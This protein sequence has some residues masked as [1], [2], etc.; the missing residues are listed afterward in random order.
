MKARANLVQIFGLSNKTTQGAVSGEKYCWQISSRKNIS[1]WVFFLL[2]SL[3]IFSIDLQ[4]NKQALLVEYQSPSPLS[5]DCP[6]GIPAEFAVFAL[7]VHFWFLGRRFIIHQTTSR[8]IK[9]IAASFFLPLND[10]TLS[11]FA[12]QWDAACLHKWWYIIWLY[13]CWGWVLLPQWFL[14]HRRWAGQMIQVKPED[15]PRRP[16]SYAAVV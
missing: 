1:C 10:A 13:Y 9:A 2:I 8:K 5:S 16:L 7:F 3:G 14:P 11:I 12:E 15:E 6:S 4:Q